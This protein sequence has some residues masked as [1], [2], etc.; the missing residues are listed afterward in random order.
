MTKLRFRWVYC[1]VFRLGKPFGYSL[2]NA[3]VFK[4]VLKNLGFDRC[5][6]LFS[7]AAPI[8]A[9]ILEYLASIGI[10]IVETFGMTE[11]SGRVCTGNAQGMVTVQ[12]MVWDGHKVHSGGS[13]ISQIE[14]GRYSWFETWF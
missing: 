6:T 7:G 10:H 2:A 5:H 12:Y 11:S 14:T 9:D 8:S 1:F 3:L 13:R 4:N